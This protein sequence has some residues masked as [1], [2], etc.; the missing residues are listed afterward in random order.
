VLGTPFAAI[1][2]G[3]LQVALIITGGALMTGTIGPVV[4]VVSDVVHPGLRATAI[5][6][7]FV[8]QN[9]FG[10]AIGPLLTGLLAD[11]YGLP[12]A[13]ALTPAACACA[14]IA[15]FYGARC[16]VGDRSYVFGVCSPALS[17]RA[18]LTGT[19][20]AAPWVTWSPAFPPRAHVRP[21]VVCCR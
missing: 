9:L 1:A 10:L 3:P 4:A 12:V 5:S 20:A 13:L 18:A 11:L 8:I 19:L 17:A 16:Y 7:A 14:A 6:T 21:C 15:L 2:P